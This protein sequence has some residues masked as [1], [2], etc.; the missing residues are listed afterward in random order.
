[1]APRFTLAEDNPDFLYLLER[2]IRTKFPESYISAFSAAEDALHHVLNEGTDIVIS[3]HG[4]GAMDG[5]EFIRALRQRGYKIPIIMVSGNPAAKQEA[6]DAGADEFLEKN[7]A[8]GA[9]EKE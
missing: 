2:M 3:D 9:L 1:M 7:V 8:L 4:M 6:L 5:T